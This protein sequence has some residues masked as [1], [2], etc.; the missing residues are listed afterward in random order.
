MGGGFVKQSFEGLAM[1]I[2]ASLPLIHIIFH[3]KG[4]DVL[5]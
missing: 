5:G 4:L 2:D 3:P 1:G